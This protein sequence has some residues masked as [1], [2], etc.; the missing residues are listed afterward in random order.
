MRGNCSGSR[1]TP[2]LSVEG[3]HSFMMMPFGTYT[4]AMRHGGADAFASAAE[5]NAG[6]IASSSGNAIAD[7]AL[8]SIVRL[9]SR[10]AGLTAALL[11]L[12]SS[13]KVRYLRSPGP[14]RKNDNHRW[15]LGARCA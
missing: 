7:P 4:H 11:P 3:I 13:G 9:E 1:D 5:A 15:P 12:S 8:L 2:A 14:K 6:N 10:F